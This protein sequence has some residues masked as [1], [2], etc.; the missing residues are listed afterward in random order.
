MLSPMARWLAGQR[1]QK[2]TLYVVQVTALVVVGFFFVRA[3]LRDW[4][5]LQ[6]QLAS[7]DWWWVGASLVV[8]TTYYL[9]FILGWRI[10]LHEFGHRVT[11]RQAVVADVVSM[12]AK[13]V[14]GGV[15]A[16]AARVVIARRYGL[17][18]GPVLA[19][20]G[21]EA[22]LAAISGVIVFL[23]SL[24]FHAH[25]HLPLPLWAL[26]L[27]TAALITVLHPRIYGPIC[28]RVLHRL[29]NVPI[30]R[31]DLRVAVL[32]LGFYAVTWV[33]SGLS[34]VCLIRA[35]EPVSFRDQL[36]YVSGVGAIGAIVTVLA[37]F[38]PSGLGAREGV[39]YALLLPITS[40]T[41]ALLVVT[42][43]RIVVTA[44]E[45]LILAG[46]SG[47]HVRRAFAESHVE[48]ADLTG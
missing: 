30:P 40:P 27:F 1:A 42:L 18:P 17:P 26:L 2:H 12:L 21:Y 4:D 46:A 22:G 28:D 47:L 19:S 31:L 29:G 39:M 10:I 14:P 35:I 6:A 23:A 16:P 43:S 44:S 48:P 38:T 32:I 45:L 9:V 25:V 33:I 15:W 20:V 5:T 41:T 3:V 34:T 13:Y 11:Y 8:I 37:F 7:L 36:L 24:T